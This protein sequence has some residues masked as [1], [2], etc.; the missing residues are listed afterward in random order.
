MESIFAEAAAAGT[1]GAAAALLFPDAGPAGQTL[2]VAGLSTV[3]AF[4]AAKALIQPSPVSQA[5]IEAA[6]EARAEAKTAGVAGGKIY[7][8][9]AE[10]I[11]AAVMA[12]AFFRSEAILAPGAAAG[13]AG[14]V[15]A[16]GIAAA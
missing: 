16:G 15:M 6:K 13:A 4:A 11:E 12:T 5:A 3:A 7:L 10:R 9:A 8:A 14:S 2:A 1:V